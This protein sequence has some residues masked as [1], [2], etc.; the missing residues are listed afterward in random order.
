MLF[1][2]DLALQNHW[3]ETKIAVSAENVRLSK[4]VCINISVINAL[5]ECSPVLLD[6]LLLLSM[7]QLCLNCLVHHSHAT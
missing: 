7:Q 4:I 5:G 1:S 3:A 2:R 6:G